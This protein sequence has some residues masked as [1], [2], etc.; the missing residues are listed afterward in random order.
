MCEVII[1][2]WMTLFGTGGVLTTEGRHI[3]V[4]RFVRGLKLGISF[5][6]YDRGESLPVPVGV[7][8]S[9]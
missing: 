4:G 3:E 7:S 9:P 5:G 1:K 8:V 2:H 6:G